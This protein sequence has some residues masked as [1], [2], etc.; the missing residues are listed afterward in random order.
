VVAG[1]L[2]G[3]VNLKTAASL[4]PLL[5]TLLRT[6]DAEEKE[7]KRTKRLEALEKQFEAFKAAMSRGEL[8]AKS[9]VLK[10]EGG[11]VVRLK[12]RKPDA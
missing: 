12:G 4:A 8:T 6:F 5:N 9:E 1:V 7:E 11:L 3:P 2:G 10:S